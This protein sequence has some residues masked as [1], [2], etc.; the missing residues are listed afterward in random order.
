[1]L[2]R[3]SIIERAYDECMTEMFAKAQP[4]VDYH[5]LLKD[6][7]EGKITDEGTP[8]YSRYYLSYEEFHYILEK[9]IDAYGMSEYWND[10]MD[11]LLRY[12]QGEGRKDIWIPDRIDKDGFKHPGYRSSTEVPHIKEAINKALSKYYEG[13]NDKVA[14]KLA[15]IVIEYINNCKNYYRF[16][17]EASNFS[18]SIAL[19]CS[20]TSNKESVINYWKSQGIDIEVK[21]RNPHLLWDRDYYGE[22]FEQ[23]MIDEYG[24][25]WEKITWDN[26]YNT[27]DG[28]KKLVHEF[29]KDKKEFKEYYIKHSGKKLIVAKF[30]DNK[31]KIPINKFIKDYIH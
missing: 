21:D 27:N 12:F 24:E 2:D 4:S 1:M 16:D 6:F 10:T 11:V 13:N 19:G 5:Q 7:K 17:R 20:P 22:E 15:H 23:V 3:Q 25:N 26:Y 14:M 31:V 30:N 29:L 9:Y 18:A 28:K 8:I